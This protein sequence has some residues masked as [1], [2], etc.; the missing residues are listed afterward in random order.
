[1]FK[2]DLEK[3]EEPEIKFPVFIGDHR[4][5]KR[6][7]KKKKKSTSLSTLKPLTLWIITNC[8]KFLKRWKYRTTLPAT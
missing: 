5:G 6:I 4:K 2:L 7:P 8:G 3:P 1:M